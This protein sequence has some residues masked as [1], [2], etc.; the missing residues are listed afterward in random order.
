MSIDEMIKTIDEARKTV[1]SEEL[2]NKLANIAIF[3]I[4][5]KEL[6]T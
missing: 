6:V 3:L 4:K 1:Q 2:Q 5:L